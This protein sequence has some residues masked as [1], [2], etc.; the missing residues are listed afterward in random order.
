VDLKQWQKKATPD[1]RRE[2]RTC[3]EVGGLEQ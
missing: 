1:N 3:V 2:E